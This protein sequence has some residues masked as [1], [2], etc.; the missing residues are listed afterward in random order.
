MSTEEPTSADP[1]S[2]EA[3]AVEAAPLPDEASSPA[4][5]PASVSVGAATPAGSDAPVGA[6]AED[7][8]PSTRRGA[9]AAQFRKLTKA[10]REGDDAMVESVVIQLSQ[11]R[12]Y[13]APLA[14]VV[15][16]FSMLFQGLKLLITNWRLTLI[17]L[18]PAM[19]IWLAMVDLKA[20]MLH[21]KEF[22]V[23]RGPIL[24]VIV[25]AIAI[26]TAAAFYLN[27]VSRSRSPGPARRRSDRRSPRPAAIWPSCSAGDSWSG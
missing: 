11:R 5:D 23:I 7:A 9:L 24:I 12:R 2:I 26:V 17:Q 10:I 18:L 22:R 1:G 13:L 8:A 3:T 25:L 6:T 27:A 4:P 19:W 14:F 20:H 16:A 15:G 21:G